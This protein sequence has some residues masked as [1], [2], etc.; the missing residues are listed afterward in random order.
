VRILVGLLG[1]LASGGTRTGAIRDAAGAST[2]DGTEGGGAGLLGS[3]G[4]ILL[5]VVVIAI[6]IAVVAAVILFRTRGVTEPTSSEG[7]WTCPK[8]GS[9]NM[10]AA[11]RC[12]T[13]STWRAT[14]ARPTPSASP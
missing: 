10:D 12:H 14:T 3:L 13:C 11:A 7:W 1:A 4:P 2:P 6:V 8:C 9:S 5:V